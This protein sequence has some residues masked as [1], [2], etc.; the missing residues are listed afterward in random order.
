MS[1]SF[2]NQ[3]KVA[4]G[5]LSVWR[6]VGVNFVPM[7]M[8]VVNDVETCVVGRVMSCIAMYDDREKVC[9]NDMVLSSIEALLVGVRCGLAKKSYEF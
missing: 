4:D 2:W 1:R 6:G 5:F 9:H 3:A 8:M 7:L